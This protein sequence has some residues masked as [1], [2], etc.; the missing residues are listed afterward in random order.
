VSSRLL[1]RWLTVR[2][3]AGAGVQSIVQGNGGWIDTGDAVDATF[4]VDC[5]EAKLPADGVVTL[6]LETSPSKDEVSFAPVVP[7]MTL[8][9]SAA[10]VVVRTILTPSTVPLARWLRWRLSTTA[11]GGVWDATMRI[12]MTTSPFSYFIPTQ[13]PG[14]KLW[15][16]A[17]MGITLNSTRVSQWNDLSGN[18]INVAQATGALQP[19]FNAS[20][21][22]YSRQPTLT[23]DAVRGDTLQN[24]SFALSQPFTVVIAGE[25]T[26]T[27][28]YCAFFDSSV[29][30]RVT[31]RFSSSSTYEL[32]AGTDLLG[33]AVSTAKS[34]FAAIFNTTSSALYVTNSASSTMSGDTGTNAISQFYVGGPAA[35]SDTFGGKIAELAV[36]SS[37]LTPAQRR[38]I[39]NYLGGRYGIAVS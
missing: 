23:F 28:V 4:V 31:F 26:T 18:G 39:F 2:G 14:C 32:Y 35:D 17:D 37:A 13:L 38:R 33:P 10:P 30:G 12:A 1:Q 11:T 3:D 5:R 9:G 6:N 20:D 7:P 21:A 15:L 36:F 16:R 24:T 8:V 29:A 27:G 19:L 34:A 22:S 25:C